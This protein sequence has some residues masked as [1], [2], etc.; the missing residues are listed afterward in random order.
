MFLVF[1][2]FSLLP[3]KLLLVLPVAREQFNCLLLT[4][5]LSVALV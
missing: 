3:A 2:T 1:L 5:R 4:S